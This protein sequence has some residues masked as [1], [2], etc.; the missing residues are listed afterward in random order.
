MRRSEITRSGTEA[1]R[2]GERQH[3]VLHRFDFVLFGTQA[4]R[5]QAQQ[6]R[7]VVDHQDACF[8][9]GGL[10]HCGRPLGRV[11]AIAQVAFDVG[12]GIEL[13]LCVLELLAQLG[14]FIHLRLQ[15]ALRRGR[16]ALVI[17]ALSIGLHAI[18]VGLQPQLAIELRQFHQRHGALDRHQRFRL[19]DQLAQQGLCLRRI[20]ARM[21]RSCQQ[22]SIA[23]LRAALR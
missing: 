19:R 4:N 7:I 12:D 11:F 3:A 9:F 1:Q 14:V 2:G 16:D 21:S 23:Q 22:Q 18:V 5:Q 6:P 10:I 8:A 15:P 17:A 20:A 13:G